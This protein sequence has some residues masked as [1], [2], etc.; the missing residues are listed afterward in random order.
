MYTYFHSPNLNEIYDITVNNYDNKQLYDIENLW[1]GADV[2]YN[3][4]HIKLMVEDTRIPNGAVK[5][6]YPQNIISQDTVEDTDD[7][8]IL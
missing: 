5:W 4:G 2:D 6:I 3:C 7:E 8:F 1:F